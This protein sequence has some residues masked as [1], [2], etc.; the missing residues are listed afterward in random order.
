M[1][2]IMSHQPITWNDDDNDENDDSKDDDFD[3]SAP[4]ETVFLLISSTYSKLDMN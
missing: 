2:I 4:L 3:V 1:A